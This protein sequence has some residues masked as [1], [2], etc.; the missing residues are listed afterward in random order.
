MCIRYE[1]NGKSVM[2]KVITKLLSRENISSK[3]LHSLVSERFATADL[4]SKIIEYIC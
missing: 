4:F 1:D 2:L 3:T